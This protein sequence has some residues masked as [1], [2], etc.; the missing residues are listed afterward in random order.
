MTDTSPA[1]PAPVPPPPTPPPGPPPAEATPQSGDAGPPSHQELVAAVRRKLQ[2]SLLRRLAGRKRVSDEL[3]V[4]VYY[5]YSWAHE[6]LLALAAAGLS[7]P[8]LTAALP[9]AP[10][11]GEKA[12]TTS[13]TPPSVLATLQAYP[14]W[15]AAILTTALVA[16]L[17]LRGFVAWKK[18]QDRGPQILACARELGGLEADLDAT[19]GAAGNPLPALSKLVGRS[20]EVV[21]RYFKADLW[22]WPIG[23]DGLDGEIEDQA[24]GLC[25][26]YEGNW[27]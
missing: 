14:G 18:L 12:S 5:A 27:K 8:V 23:P 26:R 20:K 7:H 19:L 15:V 24:A 6:V 16:W 22:P 10:A 11:A 13:A 25:K 2:E 21:D 4:R 3:D 17:A 1:V 9:P